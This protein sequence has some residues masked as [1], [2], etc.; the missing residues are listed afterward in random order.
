MTSM[1]GGLVIMKNLIFIFSFSF[2][3]IGA[4]A[5]AAQPEDLSYPSGPYLGQKPSGLTPEIFAPGIVSTSAALVTAT[6][7]VGM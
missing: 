1:E 5:I 2:L 6:V 3:L 7:V 4:T